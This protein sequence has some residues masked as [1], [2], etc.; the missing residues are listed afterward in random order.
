ME[1]RRVKVQGGRFFFPSFFGGARWVEIS[2]QLEIS[3]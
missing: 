3:S 1:G 2:R